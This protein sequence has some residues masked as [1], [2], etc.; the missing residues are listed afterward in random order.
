MATVALTKLW[1]NHLATGAAIAAHTAPGRTR[2]LTT[3]GEVRT[4][5]SSTRRPVAAPAIRDHTYTFTLRDITTT[6]HDT[7]AAWIGQPVQIRN[8]RGLLLH[9][10][11][12][13]IDTAERP[14]EHLYD[15]TITTTEI[16]PAPRPAP[17]FSDASAL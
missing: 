8:D 14:G 12:Y 5:G 15:A 16:T 11:Y 6:T 1:I 13:G 10:V 2:R 17:G 9:A 3:P 4:Y 7:L